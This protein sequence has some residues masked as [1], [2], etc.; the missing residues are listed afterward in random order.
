MKI[1]QETVE[2]V[3]GLARL[4][5]TGEEKKI[6]VEQ[7]GDILNYMDKLGTLDTAG[8]KPMEHVEPVSNV[9]REDIIE[10]S[11][12]RKDILANAPDKEEGAFKVPKIVE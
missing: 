1:S 9:F 7:M 10:N 2:Y 11:F 5:L 6:L 8:I 4:N 12:T 3:A